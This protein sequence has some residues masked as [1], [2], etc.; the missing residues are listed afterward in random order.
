MST[1]TSTTKPKIDRAKYILSDKKNETIIKKTGEIDGFNYK[2][3]Y[4]E[5][6]T[7]YVLDWTNGVNLFILFNL[8]FNL[9]VHR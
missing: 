9:D 5:N 4:L 2:I 3:R 8:F 7:V 6:C 1:N